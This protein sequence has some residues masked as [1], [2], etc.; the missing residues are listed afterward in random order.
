M[1]MMQPGHDSGCAYVSFAAVLA[2]CVRSNN[3]E[4]AGSAASTCLGLP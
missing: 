3:G 4:I 2:Q 1:C